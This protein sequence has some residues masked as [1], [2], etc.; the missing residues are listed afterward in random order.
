MSDHQRCEF[1]ITCDRAGHWHARRGDGL[2]EGTFLDHQSAQ[3]FARRESMAKMALAFG[4]NMPEHP[5]DR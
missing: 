4:A 2:V 3:R 1:E 5:Q